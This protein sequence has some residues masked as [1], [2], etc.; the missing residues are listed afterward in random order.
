MGSVRSSSSSRE[1]ELEAKAIMVFLKQVTAVALLV[2]L[3]VVVV[4]RALAQ[5]CQQ[6]PNC[7]DVSKDVQILS[8]RAGPDDLHS[9]VHVDVL[10]DVCL[11]VKV[12]QNADHTFMNLSL[13]LTL[14][15][16]VVFETDNATWPDLIKGDGIC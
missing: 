16:K 3:V 15:G 12:E 2:A 11:D 5:D 13:A 9:C 10:G 1:Y 7:T 8:R 4:P 6:V 14:D